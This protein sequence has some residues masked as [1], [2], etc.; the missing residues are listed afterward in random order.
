[1]TYVL[2]IYFILALDVASIQE[3]TPNLATCKAEAARIV[4]ELDPPPS[5]SIHAE[6]ASMVIEIEV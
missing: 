1:M 4:S 3:L 6:C 5:M 2:T